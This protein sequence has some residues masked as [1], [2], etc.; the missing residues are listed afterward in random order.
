MVMHRVRLLTALALLSVSAGCLHPPH[1]GAAPGHHAPDLHAAYEH[2]LA[3]AQVPEG[4]GVPA[5]APESWPEVPAPPA[6]PQPPQPETPTAPEPEAPVLSPVEGPAPSPIE[7]PAPSIVEGPAPTTTPPAV[8]G[9]IQ[10]PAAGPEPAIQAQDAE[11]AE[12]LRRLIQGEV[13]G[14]QQARVVAEERYRTGLALMQRGD[15][16]NA[17]REFEAAIQAWPG[18]REAHRK[19]RETSDTLAGGGRADGA[20]QM[21][22]VVDETVVK[23]QQNHIE[24][25]NHIRAGERFFAARQYPEALRE[26]Q[27]A[28][29][30]IKAIPYE[31]LPLKTRLADLEAIIA[32]TNAELTAEEE[33]RRELQKREAEALQAA[34]EEAH[35]GEILEFIGQ[36]LEQAFMLF[37]QRKFDGCARICD[38]ILLVDPHYVVARE[39]KKDALRL[40]HRIKDYAFLAQKVEH[41]KR[42]KEESREAVIPY[43]K[44]VRFPSR[45]EWA[46][47]SRRALQQAVPVEEGAEEL[48]E[49]LAVNN[50]LETKQL[51]GFQLASATL[52]EAL[53]K[54]RAET[55]MNLVLD[56][57]VVAAK[58]LGDRRYSLNFSRASARSVL[59]TL[60][61]EFDLA[62]TVR[63][64]RIIFITDRRTAQGKPR[65]QLHEIAD[66]IARS[67]DRSA[68]QIKLMPGLTDPR[69]ATTPVIEPPKQ[70]EFDACAEDLMRL[71]RTNVAPGFWDARTCTLKVTPSRQ[72]LAYAPPAVQDELKQFLAT[73]RGNTSTMVAIT[74]RFLA[75]YDD[76]L[77]Q[78][79]VDLVNQPAFEPFIL[80]GNVPALTTDPPEGTDT[81]DFSGIRGPGFVHQEMAR[82]EFW[83]VRAQGYHTFRGGGVGQYADLEVGNRLLNTGGIAI[84]W[85]MIG[86]AALQ[87]VLSAVHKE[88]KAT[89]MQAPRITVFNTQRAHIMAV[90]QQAYI[91]DLTAQVGGATAT[92]DPEI[93]ILNTGIV[94]DVKPIVSHDRRYVTLEMRPSLAELQTIRNLTLFT[95]NTVQGQFPVNIQ[96]PYVVLQRAEATVI[97]PDR[98]TVVLSG[99][100]DIVY[101]DTEASVPILGDLPILSFL[102]KRQSKWQE[103]RRLHIL[104]TPEIIDLQE[105]EDESM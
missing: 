31:Y 90:R 95:A 37:D 10:E 98:G 23:L 100:K 74:T 17:K 15:F 73:L 68:S 101:R 38:N 36:Q 78:V 47:I 3:A 63:P 41:W 60:L 44:T 28:V 96:L 32:R 43:A 13:V 29:F 39:L 103:E 40:N 93:G 53:D 48:T 9:P 89:L 18:H 11:T 88:N 104:V 14:Q 55:E 56:R 85:Q 54:L 102:F 58:G 35:R 33:R 83:D 67:R 22:R 81:G 46:Q 91:S 6:P 52:S 94:L 26:F 30:K 69:A 49:L 19:L 61:R 27:E 4:F 20:E 97:A 7:A 12:I 2:E 72:L 92:L 80:T 5:P 87:Q 1:F 57:R 77:E 51:D 75:T 99:F 59:N 25:N 65:A 8:P 84:Q 42:L 34:A 50:A 86:E 70:P 79:G 45:E 105:I 76:S 82:T 64:G 71:I 16:T 66:I 21:R 62:Y 24:I